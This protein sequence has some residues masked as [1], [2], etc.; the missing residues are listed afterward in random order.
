MSHD[1]NLTYSATSDR[2]AVAFAPRATERGDCHHA[3]WQGA[4]RQPSGHNVTPDT[5]VTDAVV[6]ALAK[7]P[8]NREAGTEGT[9][10]LLGFMNASNDEALFRLRCLQIGFIFSPDVKRRLF[11]SRYRRGKSGPCVQAIVLGSAPAVYRNVVRI[12][13]TYP[14]AKHW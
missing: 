10:R 2:R 7:S 14:S 9:R 4:D 1:S 5:M 3:S 8:R 11:H 13:P 6:I 12:Y